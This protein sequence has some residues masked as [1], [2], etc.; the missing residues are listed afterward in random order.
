MA[1]P[2][3][4]IGLNLDR[5]FPI[6]FTRPSASRAHCSD[7]SKD[8]SSACH[9][10]FA[11]IRRISLRSATSWTS[12]HSLSLLGLKTARRDNGRSLWFDRPPSPPGNRGW[13]KVERWRGTVD[14]NSNPTHRIRHGWGTTSRHRRQRGLHVG[15][16]SPEDVLGRITAAANGNIASFVNSRHNHGIHVTIVRTNNRET[17]RNDHGRSTS[18]ALRLALEDSK[19]YRRLK[20]SPH[21]C[22]HPE[23]HSTKDWRPRSLTPRSQ[24]PT[25]APP[26]RRQP[27]VPGQSRQPLL[28]IVSPG[29]SGEVFFSA[30][31]TKYGLSPD[32]ITS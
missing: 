22:G 27:S 32:S 26:Q 1:M 4:L 18:V 7:L 28:P 14:L 17:R 16:E 30:G 2:K 23:P 13:L 31:P 25:I 11:S 5:E 15:M 3:F 24:P 21:H 6:N 8:H 20:S 12:D 29:D 10:T 19:K 9:Q